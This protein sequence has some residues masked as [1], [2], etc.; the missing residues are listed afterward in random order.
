MDGGNVGGVSAS[1]HYLERVWTGEY[2]VENA[3]FDRKDADRQCGSI[4]RTVESRYTSCMVLRLYRL[5]NLTS[6]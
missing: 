6:G 2:A 3:A 1:F 5:S 4:M